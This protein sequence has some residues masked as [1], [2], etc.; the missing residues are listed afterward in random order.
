M[1]V[2]LSGIF[3]VVRRRWCLIV[4]PGSVDWTG[5]QQ[6]GKEEIPCLLLPLEARVEIYNYTRINSWV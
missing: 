2:R 6:D 5:L 4:V 1:D 3:A